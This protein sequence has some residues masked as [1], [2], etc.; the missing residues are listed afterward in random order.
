MFLLIQGG[1]FAGDVVVLGV[2]VAMLTKT[3]FFFIK[4]GRKVFPGKP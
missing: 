4:K 1:K 3:F 2:L